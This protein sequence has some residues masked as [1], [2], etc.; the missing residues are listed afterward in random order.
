[1][2][3]I[4]VI[5]IVVTKPFEGMFVY[6]MGGALLMLDGLGL[7]F[8]LIIN[9]ISMLVM[10]FA[11]V[12][13]E[14]YTSKNYFWALFMLLITGLNGVVLAGDLIFLLIFIELASIV[15]AILVGFGIDEME[16]EAA[17]KY[18]VI[19]SIAS[20]FTALAFSMIYVHT[21]QISLA[22][23]ASVS[24]GWSSKLKLQAAALLV[25]GLATKAAILPFHAW[26]PDAHPVAP[27][28]VSAILSGVLIKVL[29]V[30][31]II[32][33]FY[34]VLGLTASVST[35]L[36]LLGA[37]SI[38]V[39]S[40]LAIAQKDMKRL[41]ACSSIAQIGY[42]IMALGIATPMGVMAGLFHVFSHSI[43][44]PLLFLTAGSVEHSTGTRKMEHLGGLG[45][46][47]PV[48]AMASMVGSLSLAGMPPFS[49]FWS[50]FFIIIACVQSGH[51]VYA[52]IAAV[53]SI[54]TL[55]YIL[56]M[57]K[58]VFFG[59]F[60]HHIK[61]LKKTPFSMG[62]AMIALAL[63]SLLTGIFFQLVV[64]I[65]I[66]PAVAAVAAGLYYCQTIIGGI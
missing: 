44:K 42:I 36:M 54:M 32:R 9:V 16:L 47:M 10:V 15:S 62:L 41:L 66:N 29:G 31:V 26:L 39:G 43:M 24:A 22:G 25:I 4:L 5:T 58:N 33:F 30:Y 17:I 50:K 6:K 12:Y 56:L 3:S 52:G 35:T 27:A 2:L 1:L 61:D 63:L 45:E 13:L 64:A 37:I 65:I 14:K 48:T 19:G 40:F 38:I 34:N 55:S 28:P 51:L 49:G 11:P 59:V 21:G 46:K 18:F 57:Q 7:L 23:I 60:P 20:L 8:L 53:G